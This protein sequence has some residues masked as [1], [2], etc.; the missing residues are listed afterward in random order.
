MAKSKIEWSLIDWS[1]T[2]KEIAAL[3]GL[4]TNSISKKRRLLAPESIGKHRAEKDMSYLKGKPYLD[5]VSKGGKKNQPLAT[6]AAKKSVRGGKFETHHRAEKW[7]V[8][9]PEKKHFEV[10]N[11]Y[12]FVRENS[13]LF[14]PG[15]VV[16]KRSGGKRGTGGEYCNATAGL[17]NVKS[18]KSSAWKGWSLNTDSLP[19]HKKCSNP[20][21]GLI[22]PVGDFYKSKQSK[23]G[24][25]PRCKSCY[26]NEN[27]LYRSTDKGK[28]V[29][30]K[31][32]RKYR[33][34]NLEKEKIRAQKYRRENS[35]AHEEYQREYQKERYRK[36]KK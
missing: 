16:W 34:N 18:G 1:K 35:E 12:N 29:S 31:I 11:L 26:N 14:K 21:C 4:R 25:T 24:R 20:E 19:T 8:V 23:D 10:T 9:S 5:A 17:L 7:L 22:K 33:E 28:E 30:R 2:T 6:E 36:N 13:E 32:T 3:T 27:K 15:D